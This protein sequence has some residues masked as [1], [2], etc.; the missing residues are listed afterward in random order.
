MKIYFFINFFGLF[1][2]LCGSW[3]H[4]TKKIRT[5]LSSGSPK[6]TVN[7]ATQEIL[8]NLISKPLPF[9]VGLAR[10]NPYGSSVEIEI[11]FFSHAE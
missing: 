5:F 2:E 1:L 9:D 8:N 4:L 10:N 7:S 6:N 11:F 3:S